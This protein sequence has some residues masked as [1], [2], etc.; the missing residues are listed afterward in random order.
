MTF[1]RE[2]APAGAIVKSLVVTA[3]ADFRAVFV[4]P[5]RSIGRFIACTREAVADWRVTFG[6]AHVD[7]DIYSIMKKIGSLKLE[8]LLKISIGENYY[9]IMNI[10]NDVN[11]LKQFIQDN[12]SDMTLDDLLIVI[13]N[14]R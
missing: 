2:Q 4:T 7:N 9:E 10:K 14:Y 6:C 5:R 3:R 13:H 11:F 8:D 12:K 1:V